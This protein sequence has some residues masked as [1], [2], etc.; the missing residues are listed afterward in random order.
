MYFKM[1]SNEQWRRWGRIRLQITEIFRRNFAR[2]LVDQAAARQHIFNSNSNASNKRNSATQNNGMNGQTTIV[3]RPTSAVKR[4]T[5]T[6]F[7]SGGSSGKKSN[8][9]FPNEWIENVWKFCCIPINDWNV[10]ILFNKMK[11]YPINNPGHI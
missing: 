8:D 5:I 1:F 3:T 6:R 10:C 7:D 9:L 2:S 11:P 4:L